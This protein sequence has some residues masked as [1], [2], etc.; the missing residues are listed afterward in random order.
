MMIYLIGIDIGG[1][2][3]V[4]GLMDS[5]GSLLHKLKQP[6]EAVMGSS[7][8]FDKIKSMVE[9]LLR[10]MGLKSEE[11]SAIGVGTPG[12]I[13]PV[14]GISIFAGNLQWVQVH[15]AE[16]IRKRTGIPTYIDNDVRMYVY[17]ES[18]CGAAKGYEHVLGITIGTGLAAAVINHGQLY[19]G[20]GYMAGEL[21]HIVMP[22]ISYTCG[23]GLQGCLET[24]VS[25]TGI[26]RQAKELLQSGRPSILRDWLAGASE[27]TITAADVSRAY[28]AGDSLSIEVMNHTGILLGKGLA[29]AVTLYSPDVIVIGGGAALAGD[30]LF[31][32]MREQLQKSVYRGYWERLTIVTA[33]MIDDAGI[34]GSAMA[35]SQRLKAET[36]KG[37]VL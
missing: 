33:T 1:T 28:D 10:I 29:N 11:I 7:Y 18:V 9:E 4:C 26:A 36:K 31:A 37:E 6:T 15:T 3:V 13:D 34:V 20:G 16:E 19:Y 22:E 30:R 14:K 21:G 24:A 32:P 12:F 17:G 27:D 23:C 35:A 5:E 25:A 8:V 2:N